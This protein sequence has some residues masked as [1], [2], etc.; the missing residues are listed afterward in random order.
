MSNVILVE[1][2]AKISKIRSILIDA[3]LFNSDDIEVS[4][5]LGHFRD[6]D[7][8]DS[9]VDKKNDYNVTYKIT[10]SLEAKNLKRLTKS[11]TIIWLAM[12]LDREGE[13]IAWHVIDY[14]KL[15]TSK[16][17]RVTFHE[18]TSSAIIHAF[19][20]PRT[21]DINLADA[22]K[23]RR[24]MDRIIGYGVTRI[25]W[26][27]MNGSNISAGRV[28][29]S[30]MKI[31]YDKELLAKQPLVSGFTW[32]IKGDFKI[33]EDISISIT[34]KSAITPQTENDTISLLLT[35][36]PISKICHCTLKDFTKNAPKT[37]ITST[38]QQEAYNKLGFS[39]TRTMKIA[40]ELYEKGLITYMRTDSHAISKEFREKQLAPYIINKYDSSYIK[41][42]ECG[43]KT[44][45]QEA[46][47]CIRPTKLSTIP[48]FQSPTHAKLYDLIF[49]QTIASC[50]IPSSYIQLTVSFQNNPKVMF[51][52]SWEALIHDGWEAVYGNKTVVQIPSKQFIDSLIGKKVSTGYNFIAEPSLSKPVERYT[53]ASL[54]KKLDKVGI[55]R[56]STYVST[57]GKLMD[58]KYI[59]VLDIK[60]EELD[61][62][63]FH[64]VGKD[65]VDKRV[66]KKP[67]F[68]Q[69]NRIIPTEK[70][71]Q[72]H[73]FMES[74]FPRLISAE[75]TKNMEDELDNVAKGQN[76]Y[77]T[78]MRKVDSELSSIVIAKEKIDISKNEHVLEVD[79]RTYVIRDAKYGPVI[80]NG[81]KYIPIEGFMKGEKMS[82]KKIGKEHVRFLASLPKEISLNDSKKVYAEINKYGL[83]YKDEKQKYHSFRLC[84]IM[85]I[86]L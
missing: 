5:T 71:S 33:N 60:G 11:A 48:S 56:P 82:M 9:A 26:K 59:E 70:G 55:G 24:V 47:E 50:M 12:D 42:N 39:I 74:H 84:D 65:K 22:Q 79:G 17:R 46:H 53:E 51:I 29:S 80:Q 10:K 72:I 52:G 61:F 30:C 73:T 44:G 85:S 37:L 4:A 21:L 19:R 6:L 78:L 67:S 57:I 8:K 36:N 31:I 35:L 86:Y 3:H 13:G 62:V 20:N 77:V 23:S 83:Y 49:K 28:Q 75:Y 76:D 16:Y 34:A 68:S 2:P 27:S 54:V 32:T 66:E 58:K 7:S 15:P 14:C 64:L 69:K 38:L 18:I 40:Q 63:T 1:S 25:L 41:F 43:K 45:A 81:S